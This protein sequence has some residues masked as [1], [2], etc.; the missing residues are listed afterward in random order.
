MVIIN[1]FNEIY[2]P[3]ITY[4]PIESSILEYLGVN[5]SLLLITTW[6]GT[7]LIDTEKGKVKKKK[8]FPKTKTKLVEYLKKIQNQEVLSEEEQLIKGISEPITV[9]EDRLNGVGGVGEVLESILELPSNI[10]LKPEDFG[11]K[12]ELYQAALVELGKQRVRE[13]TPSDFYVVQAVKGLDDITQIS[14]LLSE[15]LHEWYG[16]HWPELD[17]IVKENEYVNL[18]SEFGYRENI[19]KNTKNDKLKALKPQDSVGSELGPEDKAAVMGFADELKNVNLSKTK[20]ENYINDRMEVLAPNITS[21][22]GPIIGARLIALTGGLNRLAKVSSSTI[23]LLGA[24]KALFRHLREGGRPPKHGI[25]FQHPLIH[26][27]PQWQRGKIAR[28][29]AGKIA[30]AAKLDYNKGKF[31]GEELSEALNRR[32]DDIRKKYPSAPIKKKGSRRTGKSTGKKKTRRGK[33][34]RSK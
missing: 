7:F 6:F 23:Q 4:L 19:L 28:A 27:A 31:N 24:E 12:P 2:L 22:T 34:G 9:V 33:R 15:R 17:K 14:N 32:I 18:I 16:L 13:S 25:I 8:I 21:L 3:N 1:L 10:I 20:L 11:F 5:M 30:I 29:F 26:N